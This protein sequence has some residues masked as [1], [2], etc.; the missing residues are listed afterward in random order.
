[1]KKLFLAIL[2]LS[3]LFA[4]FAVIPASALS[5]TES[6]KS[7]QPHANGYT[8]H[9][10]VDGDGNPVGI[11]FSKSYFGASGIAVSIQLY[12]DPNGFDLD[13]WI[14]GKNLE[15][16]HLATRTK[17]VEFFDW[18]DTTT[19]AVDAVAN[20][21]YNGQNNL[22]LSD[23]YRYNQASQGAELPIDYH[24]YKMLTIGREMYQLTNG[25]FNP[26]IY[27]LVDL[28]G[29]SSRIYSQ[30]NFG[31]P[32]DREV[33]FAEWQANG[34]PLPDQKYIDAFSNTAF[35]DFSQSAVTLTERDGNYFVTKN[36]APAVV[37]GVK[38]DQWLDLGG[39][40]KG[41]VVD[42]VKQQLAQIGQ[43]RFFVDAGSSS[44]T[45]G[46]NSTGGNIKM[47]IN[48]PFDEYAGFFPTGLVGFEIA[49]RSVS[50]SGQYVRKYTTNGIEYAHIVDGKHGAPAQTGINSITIT[51]PDDDGSNYWA[52]KADCLSTAM[53]VL[54]RDGIV[55][56]CNTGFFS[57]NN[58]DVLVFHQAIDGGKQV[59][60][61]M[62]QSALVP[63][64]ENWSQLSW[65]LKKVDGHWTYDGNAQL[66]EL[67]KTDYTWLLVVF[68]V[69]V[70]ALFTV[71]VVA[72]YTTHKHKQSQNIP[73]VKKD[74][75]FKPAD[76]MVYIVLVLVIVVLFSVFFGE[77]DQAF[78]NI[79]TVSVV[80][81]QT[82][83]VLFMYNVT[84]NEY[85]VAEDCPWSVTVTQ[86]DD[87]IVVSMERE[88]D[89]E[90]RFNQVTI[91][92]GSQPTVKMTDSICGFHQDC[93][94]NF[95]T[96]TTAG[97]TI[98]CSPNYLKVVTD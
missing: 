97:Q 13:F 21:Q 53:T 40:A 18:V 90:M 54:G 27:R 29:F 94:R 98:V 64:S 4:T 63:L 41:Y 3:L 25:A 88:F 70:V 85:Q 16:K 58:I 80:D 28:W 78:Q 46:F 17:V 96:M 89:G 45:Y 38:F 36:V 84:R 52:C 92:T 62:D 30:G 60:S 81:M 57:E 10:M 43:T 72:R 20:T 73:F 32:Y 49:N 23:I 31:L 9:S 35:T 44:Q 69:V 19:N 59:L 83:Q 48:D 95:G 56:F 93:V 75:F 6:E 47:S 15:A 91:T 77:N 74:K 79:Q 66:I 37:D 76:V 1:M 12:S 51:I 22:P 5:A 68:A 33:T 34:Y 61:N 24:T 67:P 82:N 39:I 50:T 26:A 87:G 8:L 42:L 2:I 86:V 14:G 7:Y 71:V 11:N 65:N 55:D